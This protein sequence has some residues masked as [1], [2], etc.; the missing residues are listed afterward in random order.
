MILKGNRVFAL[1]ELSSDYPE[2]TLLGY[3][4]PHD[5][6]TTRKLSSMEV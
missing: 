6:V 1:T 4:L 5:H 3:V 2:H